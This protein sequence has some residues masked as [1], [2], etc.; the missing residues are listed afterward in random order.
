MIP[1]KEQ[2]QEVWEWCG[3]EVWEWCGFKEALIGDGHLTPRRHYGWIYPKY[4]NKN[5]YETK[6][7]S[8]LPRI[9]LNNLFK[10]AVP[11]AI[12]KLESRFDAV[13]NLVRGLEL[14]FQAWLANIREGYPLEDAL[15]WAIYKVMKETK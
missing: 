4:A 8:R 2:E 15:F 5:S 9:D 6:I 14:L 12:E 11:V 13:T 7:N 3:F 1:T 10:Y